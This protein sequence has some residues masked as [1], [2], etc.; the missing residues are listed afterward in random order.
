MAAAGG[1]SQ[2]DWY[3]MYPHMYV[4][5]ARAATAEKGEKLLAH[6]I[7]QLVKLIRVVKADK[8]A[9]ALV[10]EFNQRQSKPMPPTFWTDGHT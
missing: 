7:D 10:A 5:D 8:V 6:E 2:V 4:G 3:A 9:P 1:Y